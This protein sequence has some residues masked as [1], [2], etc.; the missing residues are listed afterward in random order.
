[1]RATRA[2]QR[3]CPGKRVDP[4]YGQVYRQLY[5]KH[6]WWRSRE[7][8]ILDVLRNILP[9]GG[10]GSILDV[11]CGDGLF[12]D[13]LS[14]F[15]EVEGIEFSADLLDPNGPHRKRIRVAPFDAQFQPG[16][17][18]G[19]ITML[20]VLEHLAEPVAALQHA[21]TLLAPAGKI[22]ITVPAFNLIWT[23]HDDLNHH[24]ARYTKRSFRRISDQAGMRVE[25]MRYW[26]Q[27]PFAVK[28]L[29]RAVEKITRA[30]PSNP[31]I[32]PAWLNRTLYFVSRAEQKLFTPLPAPF[33]STLLV[34]G[35]NSRHR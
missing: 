33:G 25:V 6:W 13:Q 31:R 32:P 20:D 34:V 35:N 29:V 4:L 15:G 21:L 10:F 14:Q 1:M 30:Q 23:T 22:A 24:L 8:A 5:E 18:Y 17:S 3:P 9:D 2:L 19:L 16:K 26:Y 27:W 11:G 12:F 28:M 7:A